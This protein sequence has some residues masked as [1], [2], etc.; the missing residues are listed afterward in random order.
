V[1]CRLARCAFA[2]TILLAAVLTGCAR[3]KPDLNERLAVIPFENLSSD[4]SLDWMRRAVA[5][6]V[7]NDL[8]GS[9][10]LFAQAAESI[11]A[12]YEMQA[13]R[14]LQGY[15]YRRNGR[16]EIHAA[17]EDLKKTKTIENVDVAGFLA[18]G[19]LPLANELAR[20]VSDGARPF[21]TA[22]EATLEAYG[23]ALAAGDRQE[24][25]QGLQAA[26]ESDSK[27]AQGYL[28][29]SRIL[30]A[31]GD[32]AGAL[33]AIDAGLK[34]QPD[35][36][37]RAQLTY[38]A[39][40]I[41]GDQAARKSAL[42]S[43]TH[44]TPADARIFRELAQLQVASRE[45]SAAI[46]NFEAAGRLVPDEAQNWNELGYARAY[47]GDLEGAKQ[48]LNQ[49]QPLLP[50]QNVNGLDSLGEVSFYLGD[51]A[52]AERSFLDA[53]RK[54]RAE[55]GGGELVKAAQAR[56]MAGD[57]GNADALFRKYTQLFQGNQRGRAA[58]L[59][60]QW[61][62]MTGRRKAAMA[63]I[64]KIASSLDPDSRSQAWSQLSIWK[65][66]TGDEKAALDLAN[67]ASGAALSPRAMN[68]SA[69]CR[70]ISKPPAQA[71][72]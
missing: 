3:Q 48:A 38:T 62:F 21:E 64:E 4:L 31:S 56:L 33:Q 46:R 54:N 6:V 27:F 40:S 53:D 42:E 65:M 9:P 58:F 72:G 68:L 23:K 22:H 30:L 47:A 71:S 63:G 13:S 25:L 51:F 49:Y 44:L 60:T 16:L 61:E 7:V 55:F 20:K 15:F 28:D 39:A 17:I 37:G 29:W 36:I 32:R 50:Q 52:G 12:A 2:I 67:R 8:R 11:N 59:L 1:F 24:M 57:L 43:L 14:V 26:A 10:N 5:L 45:F 34:G 66:Q 41:R 19:A 35:A 69:V 18:Q 70:L